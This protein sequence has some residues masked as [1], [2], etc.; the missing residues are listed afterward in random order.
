LPKL[1][2]INT[3]FMLNKL[4]MILSSLHFRL[5]LLSWRHSLLKWILSHQKV[6]KKR[7]R[8]VF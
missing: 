6:L 2:H 8:F 1:Y 4:E 7:T 3:L 5:L